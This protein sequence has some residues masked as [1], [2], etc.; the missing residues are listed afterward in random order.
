MSERLPILYNKKP[1]YDIVFAQSFDGLWEELQ[2]LE[3]GNKRLCIVTDS[4]VNELYGAAVLELLE[5]RCRKAVRYVFPNGEENKTLDT[6]REVYKFLIREGFDRKDML[7]ALGGGVV[8]DLTGY[9][10]AT[11]L[12]GIDFVQVPTTLLSQADSSIGG[13]TGVDLD[14]YKNMV[15]AFKM[16]R[17]VYMNLAVLSTLEDRQFFSGFAEV[18][19]S[20]LLKDSMFYE[21]LIENM[22][23][24]CDRDLNVLQEMLKRSCGIKKLVVEKDPTEQGDRALLNLGHTIGHAIE[25]YKDFELYHGECVALGCVAAAYISWKKDMLSM[26]EYYEI[27]DMFVPFNL[28]ISIDDIDPQEILRLTKSDKKM[29]AGTIRFI[30]LKKIGKAVIDRTVTDDEIL[31]AVNEIYFSE[32][33]AHE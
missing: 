10:A 22:Y 7:I 4:R 6:V 12:R 23:E 21:W 18:M 1:C 15:G 29:D 24:I 3:C 27:R 11:Y 28:P 14:G 32:E 8:G 25:K 2:V 9:A 17:L 33:D 5:G 19:K 30:L 20:A 13:K 16:P 26:D 31:A